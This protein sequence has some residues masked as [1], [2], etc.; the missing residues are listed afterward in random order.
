MNNLALAGLIIAAA[1]G[2]GGM[3]YWSYQAGKN[4]REA[5]QQLANEMRWTFS[6]QGDEGLLSAL[7]GFSL[8]S[9]GHSRRMSNVLR[10]SAKDVPAAVFDYQYSTGSGKSR[11]TSHFTAAC[12]GVSGPP[13]PR[14][15]LR[16]EQFFDKVGDLVGFKDI[17]FESF[18]EFSK[19]YLLRGENEQEV[20]RLFGTRAIGFIEKEAGLCMEG[21]RDQLLV[22]RAR[23]RLRVEEIRPLLDLGLRILAL[24]NRQ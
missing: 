5:L 14:F 21:E 1:A 24:L 20:R 2:L 18:P 10:G 8:L 9:R 22:Y 17:D 19:R 7:G 6:P 16:P 13:L 15:T 23:R 4:R 11:H 12:I 3:A